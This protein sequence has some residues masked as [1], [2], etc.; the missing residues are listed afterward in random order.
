MGGC[1]L[2]I[3]SRSWSISSRSIVFSSLSAEMSRVRI[4][5]SLSS[6]AYSGTTLKEA[7]CSAWRRARRFGLASASNSKKRRVAFACRSVLDERIKIYRRNVARLQKS[8]LGRAEIERPSQVHPSCATSELVA[9]PAGPLQEIW[10]IAR[11]AEKTEFVF[12]ENLAH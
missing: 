6:S 4:D 5:A 1:S 2:P 10:I 8:A 7:S 9:H 11:E 3:A 12:D